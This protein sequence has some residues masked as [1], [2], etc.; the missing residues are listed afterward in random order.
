MYV[1]PAVRSIR[2][3]PSEDGS[4]TLLVR[5]ADDVTAIR[6]RIEAAGG[7]LEET[8]EFETVAVSVPQSDV[9]EICEIE[10]IESIETDQTLTIDADGAGEDVSTSGE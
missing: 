10:G 6:D 3:H 1:S 7:T 9:G 5:A 4:V 8:L 2:E